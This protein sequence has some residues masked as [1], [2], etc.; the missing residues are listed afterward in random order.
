LAALAIASDEPTGGPAEEAGTPLTHHTA[1]GFAWMLGQTLVAKVVSF[2]GTILLARLLTP[3]D[4][5]VVSL[6]YAAA[7]IPGILRDA[8]LQS[9]LVQRQQHLKRWINPVF[10]MSLA[11]GAFTMLVMMATSPLAARW[12]NE[13]R[14][15]PLLSIMGVGALTASIGTVPQALTMIQLRFR[16]QAMLAL[17]TAVLTMALNVLLAW[18]GWGPYSFIVPLVVVSALRTAA[19]WA[20]ASF[21][22]RWT[23]DLRR[24]RYLVSDSGMLLLTQILYV[25]VANGDYLI[26]GSRY[27]DDKNVV[28]QFYF[29]FNLSWQMLVLLQVN[30]A[31]VLFP[32]LSKLNAEP[33]RQTQAYLRSARLLAL[34]GVPACFLQ[35]ALARPG[36]MLIFPSKWGP[37]IPIMAV[38]SLG[39]AIHVVG[40]TYFNLAQAQGRFRLV[41]VTSFVTA[42][43]FLI[44][45]A[46]AAQHGH[47][48]AVATAEAIF[49]AMIDPLWLWTVVRRNVQKAAWEI[50]RIFLAPVA[51]AAL[52]FGLALAVARVCPESR[53]GNIEKMVVISGVAFFCYLPVIRKLAPEPWAELM[54]LVR[55]LRS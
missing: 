4:Y 49:F 20:A 8:G 24:W 45:V 5:G 51:A 30:L 47:G 14:L 33:D 1:H 37:A 32:A 3:T 11:L 35:A 18:C 53:A 6:A 13:P 39:M 46:L 36:M 50:A 10:W 38:L 16:F 23:L 17:G 29:A 27:R 26:L 2:L 12:L 19:F 34:I 48:F 42:I 25:L 15:I 21:T 54:V 31:T 44:V 41:L 22:V 28:G 52:A 40:L 7:A 55:K 9:I 43:L